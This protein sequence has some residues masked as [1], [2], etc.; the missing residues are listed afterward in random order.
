MSEV[1]DKP[2][3]AAPATA[4]RTAR[5]LGRDAGQH[6]FFGYYN[7]STWD[8]S[9][10]Y[11]LAQRTPFKDVRLTPQ[12]EAEVGFFDLTDGDRFH[13]LNRTRDSERHVQPR[14]HGF[15]AKP[16]LSGIGSPAYINSHSG[17]AHG[18]AEEILAEIG[19]DA[20]GVEAATRALL[21]A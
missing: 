8:K 2:G 11:V 13:V 6:H 15:T 4:Q 10:R 1:I 14:R 20:A 17:S 9:G 3:A 12:A 18:T 5:K 7:K 16:H 21:E 19:L